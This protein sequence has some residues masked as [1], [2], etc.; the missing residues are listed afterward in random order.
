MLKTDVEQ[1]K[2][3]FAA[4]KNLNAALKNCL[5]KEVQA[6]PQFVAFTKSFRAAVATGR[7]EPVHFFVEKNFPD[8]ELELLL[9]ARYAHIEFISTNVEQI[10]LKY[11]EEFNATYEGG[12]KGITV[13]N[14]AKFASIVKEVSELVDV[15]L[16]KAGLPV[17]N[18]MKNSF[19]ISIFEEDVLKEVFPV[20]Q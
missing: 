10:V 14:K 16:K 19:F 7:K 18:F 1:A 13:K 2:D 3:A 11:G 8:H 15:S 17:S 20:L 12:E 9:I 5:K 6:N 4:A